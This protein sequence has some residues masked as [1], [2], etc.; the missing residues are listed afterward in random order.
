[1]AVVGALAE[2]QAK[3]EAKA[4]PVVVNTAAGGM[5]GAEVGAVVAVA[6][7]GAVA[8]AQAKASAVVVSTAAAVVAGAEV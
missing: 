5:A 2:A 7:M 6:V 3:Y 8:E 1:M 4:G